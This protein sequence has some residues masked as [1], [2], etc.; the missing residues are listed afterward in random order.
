[1][2]GAIVE[3][4]KAIEACPTMFK[5]YF[6]RGFAYD[7]LS[8]SACAAST[9]LLQASTMSFTCQRAI[10]IST[11]QE[12]AKAISDYTVAWELQPTNAYTLYNRGISK[13]RAG[14]YVGAIEG[15][16][17]IPWVSP[18]SQTRT[19]SQRAHHRR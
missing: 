18:S 11:G 1:M 5:A 3:Y 10:V 12:F 15:G 13:D 4:T 9:L 19:K 2:P 7:K 8:V 16:C 17:Q 6:N 14:D